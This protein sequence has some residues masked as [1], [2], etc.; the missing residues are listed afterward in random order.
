MNYSVTLYKNTGFNAV[1]VPD[2]P[3]LLNQC[4]HINTSSIQIMQNRFLATIRLR[5]HWD[6]VK[7]CDY[8]KLGD[9]DPQYYFIVSMKM[10]DTDTCIL[11]VIMDYWTTIGGVNGLSILDGITKRVHVTDDTFGK[12]TEEDPLTMPAMPLELQTLWFDQ[13]KDSN[14]HTYIEAT[15]DIPKMSASMKGKTYKAGGGETVT[16]P[17]VEALSDFTTYKIQQT[18][19]SVQPHTML[20]DL[21][22]SMSAPGQGGKGNQEALQEGIAAIRQLGI[23][24]GAIVNQVT[25]PEIYASATQVTD[26]GESLVQIPYEADDG[27]AKTLNVIDRRI[28]EFTGKQG[29]VATNLNYEYTGARNNRTNYG[30]Y[31]KYGIITCSGES[32]EY[33]AEDIKDPDNPTAPV[34]K[35]LADPHT[36][37]RPYFRWRYVNKDSSA[38]GFFRNCVAGLKWKQVPLFYQQPA[39]TALN[40][41]RYDNSR[42]IKSVDY[43]N[44]DKKRN[45][46]AIERGTDA[47]LSFLGGVSP[48]FNSVNS[49][50]RTSQGLNPVNIVDTLWEGMKMVGD[51]L[52]EEETHDAAYYAQKRAEMSEYIV[53]NTIA[54]PTINFPYNSETLRD[55]YGN[56][57]LMYRY[58]YSAADI[59]RIDKLL[60][61]YGYRY[62]KP[63]EPSDFTN[64]QNFNYVECSH[65]TVTGHAKWINDG[66][67][68]M[69]NNGIRIWH[70]LPNPSYYNQDNPNR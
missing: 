34:L 12:Y 39:G 50:V 38:V 53:G 30:E 42:H 55:F 66:V 31:N 11:K 17:V 44:W 5:I 64:K 48:K 26:V 60:T 13:G 52:T 54:A 21:D 25:I 37:G 63:V 6:D 9:N 61:M 43:A 33:N 23:E 68:M 19:S 28:L 24:E 36:D 57:C 65:I 7:D 58:K 18:S 14:S 69:L 40:T 8:L 3:S 29:F 32:C 70:K 1:N 35:Y 16:V 51:Y 41:L 10:A 4:V 15:V 47:G 22:A 62:T 27:T 45:V 20:Y 59:N 46:E 56:G 49:R 67:S 2:T